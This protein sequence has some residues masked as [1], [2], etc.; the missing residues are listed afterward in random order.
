MK[1]TTPEE[2]GASPLAL[3]IARRILRQP[4]MSSVR[5][6]MG[7]DD[8]LSIFCG[9]LAREVI[10]EILHDFSPH[11]FPAVPFKQTPGERGRQ[12]G[13]IAKVGKLENL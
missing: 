3:A 12:D 13:M 8:N 1:N 5:E 10:G 4:A 11:L 6:A 2:T 9:F 7:T